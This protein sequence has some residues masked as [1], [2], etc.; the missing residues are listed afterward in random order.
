[1]L[2]MVL[3]SEPDAR[4]IP[5][6]GHYPASVRRSPHAFEGQGL[7]ENSMTHDSILHCVYHSEGVDDMRWTTCSTARTT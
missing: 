5:C 4:K 6:L 2:D 7:A 1:M 3:N